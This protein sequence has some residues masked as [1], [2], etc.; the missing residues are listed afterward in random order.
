VEF[1]GIAEILDKF[2]FAQRI[3]A[4]LMLL[5]TIVAI[6]L[7]P[8]LIDALTTTNAECLSESKRQG[9]RIVYL[10]KV[11]DTLD[12]KI[13]D[14]Q[15]KYTNDITRREA[16]FV[17]MLDELKHDLSV[18]P[19]K[20]IQIRPLVKKNVSGDTIVLAM[21]RV[22]PTSVEPIGIPSNDILRKIEI[23]KKQIKNDSR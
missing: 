14:N 1:K 12:F 15:R 6:T 22:P 23:M 20:K 21:D 16:E 7:G 5:M 8:K 10:E 2:T 17:A 9:T 13:I 19:E 4:L 18:V 11:M 3:L